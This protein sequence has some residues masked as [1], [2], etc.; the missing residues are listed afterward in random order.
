MHVVQIIPT[1]RQMPIPLMPGKPE[2]RR[3]RRHLCP[4][5][6]VVMLLGE[7]PGGVGDLPHRPQMIEMVVPGLAAVDVGEEGAVAV[8]VGAVHRPGGLAGA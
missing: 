4:I 7:C 6:Q 5:G 2:P 1:P 8:D 3:A